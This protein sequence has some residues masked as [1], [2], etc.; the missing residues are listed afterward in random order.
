MAFFV[1]PVSA[2]VVPPNQVGPISSN[3]YDAV[4][5]P[6]IPGSMFNTQW[7][8]GMGFQSNYSLKNQ[9]SGEQTATALTTPTL[10]LTHFNVMMNGFH[11]VMNEILPQVDIGDK[12][13]KGVI[14]TVV[15]DVLPVEF[16]S[17]PYNGAP[18]PLVQSY[19]INGE[20][21]LGRRHAGIIVNDSIRGSE[22]GDR[23]ILAQ[24]ASLGESLLLDRTL[25]RKRAILQAPS[26][27][28]AAFYGRTETA[29]T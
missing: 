2:T 1:P 25:M 26:P 21:V 11:D 24:M 19:A 3:P 9:P 4:N 16:Q 10:F 20:V 27:W 23:L 14:Q 6:R 29:M 28:L 12:V 17:A 15:W 22:D 18:P 7:G 13:V 8:H 5:A